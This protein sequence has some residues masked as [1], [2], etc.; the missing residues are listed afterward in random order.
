M[1]KRNGYG[2]LEAR[3]AEGQPAESRDNLGIDVSRGDQGVA[4]SKPSHDG[5]AAGVF[6]DVEGGQGR[7]VDYRQAH[8]ASRISRT[9]AAASSSVT[10]WPTGGW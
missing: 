9:A 3:K 2:A 7:G 5:L 1:A 10:P 6:G 4:G 8:D